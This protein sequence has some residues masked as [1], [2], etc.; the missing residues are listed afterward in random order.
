MRFV[1][2]K[3]EDVLV[4]LD[5]CDDDCVRISIGEGENKRSIAEI[6]PPGQIGLIA[7]KP[8]KYLDTV[9]SVE[10]MNY[11]RVDNPAI[12]CLIERKDKE[13]HELRSTMRRM[14]LLASQHNDSH[15]CRRVIE[16]GKEA[17][18]GDT[19]DQ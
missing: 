14:M 5:Q 12:D 19:D 16:V 15:G 6:Y 4:S 3:E 17:I 10:G 11:I 2:S 7:V 1:M 9:E 13:I 18:G 8:S